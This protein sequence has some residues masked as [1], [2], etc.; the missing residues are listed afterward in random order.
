MDEWSAE[1]SPEAPVFVCAY[2]L[3]VGCNAATALRERGFD[4]RYVRG[5]LAAWYGA[6]GA[7][8]GRVS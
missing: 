5:G 8:S 2:G 1:L 3:E 4:A 7:R 6:G